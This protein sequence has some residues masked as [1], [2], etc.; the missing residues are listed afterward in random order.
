MKK[1]RDFRNECVLSVDP[2]TA[3]VR[4]SGCGTL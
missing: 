1:R 2:E 3:R 4:S